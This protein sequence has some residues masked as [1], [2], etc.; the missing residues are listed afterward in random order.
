MALF[1]CFLQKREIVVQEG[2]AGPIPVH[3]EPRNSHMTC[4]LY[5][6]PQYRRIITGVANVHVYVIPEPGHVNGKQLGPGTWGLRILSR[7]KACAGSGATRAYHETHD[8][9]NQQSF[10]HKDAPTLRQ[11]KLDAM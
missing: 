10:R 8:R 7:S 4:L 11:R 5:L 1:R 9:Q 3:N 2:L 6:P